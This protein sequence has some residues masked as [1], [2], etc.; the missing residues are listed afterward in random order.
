MEETF[1]RAT[2]KDPSPG[3]TEEY[4]SSEQKESLQSNNTFNEHDRVYE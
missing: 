3:W 1:R 4:M 2:E